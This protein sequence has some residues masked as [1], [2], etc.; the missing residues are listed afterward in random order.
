MSAFD[1][2]FKENNLK[3]YEFIKKIHLSSLSFHELGLYDNND[4]LK[5]QDVKLKFKQVIQKLYEF[6]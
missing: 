1:H 2:I 6:D 3:P 5:R 4:K